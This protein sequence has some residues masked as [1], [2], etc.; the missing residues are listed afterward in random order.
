MATYLNYPFDQEIFVNAWQETPDPVKSA[1][2]ESGAMVEDTLI[3]SQIAND[4]FLYS[5][6]FPLD[7]SSLLPMGNVFQSKNRSL[8]ITSSP[9]GNSLYNGA[10][11]C[12]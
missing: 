8:N 4:G 12:V 1:M 5:I 3:A 11:H 10:I 9:P 7:G 6:P 2:V